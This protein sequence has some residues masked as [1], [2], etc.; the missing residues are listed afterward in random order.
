M[1]ETKAETNHSLYYDSDISH[2]ENKVMILTDLKQGIFTRI[3]R[4]EL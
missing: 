1:K 2:S 4:Q 3:K